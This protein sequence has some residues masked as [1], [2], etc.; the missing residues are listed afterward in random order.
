M[1][2]LICRHAIRPLAT[3]CGLSMLLIGAAHAD[4]QVSATASYTLGGGSTYY[5]ADPASGTSSGSV[6]VLSFPNDYLTN[7]STG[8][9]TYGGPDGNFG[10]RSSGYGYYDVTGL[11]T[12][13]QSVTNTAATAQHA[14]FNFYIT[15][16]LLQNDV[17][18]D[19]SRNSAYY[20]AAGIQFDIKRDGSSV[21][22]SGATLSTNASGTTYTQ[23][24]TNIYTQT[25]VTMYD[26]GGGHY[27]VDLGVVNAGQSISLQYKL[28]TFANGNAP[29]Y[30]DYYVPLETVTVPEQ[31]VFHPEHTY[32]QWVYDGGYGGYGSYGGYGC[33]VP[34]IAVVSGYGGCGN[35]HW[36]TITVPAST[37]VIPTHT[38]TTG[39]YTTQG[40][41]SGSHASSGDPFD[42][43]WEGR[44]T[45]VVDA[46]GNI[47]KAPASAFS[48]T[49]VPEPE[50]WAMTLGGLTVVGA[51]AARRRRQRS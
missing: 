8:I 10:S 48:V 37:E 50:A 11:F 3:A 7:S 20:V 13:T 17:R 25:G 45:D 38:V 9:H 6:D 46:T 35:G 31:S 36:E 51:A 30:G 23:T 47:G 27:S 39:G 2:K 15:P 16:G 18:S 12:L 32:N 28:S 21:W 4:T 44:V 34:T 24:G 41:P 14:I 49:M 42:I 22:N 33:E 5:L 19:L 40:E 29:G 43:N 1:S 26:V